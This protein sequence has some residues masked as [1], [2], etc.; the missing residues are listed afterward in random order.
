[1]ADPRG[2]ARILESLAAALD[3]PIADPQDVQSVTIMLRYADE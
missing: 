2:L 3:E 1:M